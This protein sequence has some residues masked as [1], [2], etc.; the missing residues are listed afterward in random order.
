[1]GSYNES[2]VG[3]KKIDKN[4][5]NNNASSPFVT[6]EGPTSGLVEKLTFSMVIHN[7]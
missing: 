7:N 3:E 1:M 2:L 5:K 4:K 6:Q